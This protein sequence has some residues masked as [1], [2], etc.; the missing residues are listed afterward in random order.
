MTTAPHTLRTAHLGE[1]LGIDD[2]HPDL[3]WR[4]GRGRQHA[5]QVH[6]ATGPDLLDSGACDLWDSGRVAG[7]SGTGI[8][9][10]G[11]PPGA[12]RRVWWRVRVWCDDRPSPWSAAATWETGL[13]TESDWA[14][15]QWITARRTDSSSR[16]PLLAK[17]F[18][19]PRAPVTARLYATAL[20]TYEATVNGVAAGPALLEPGYTAYDKR[21]LYATYDITE[22]LR[23]G[24]NTVG[25]SLG[26]GIAH[27]PRV[28]GRYAKLHLDHGRPRARA[29]L[30]VV[31]ED[32]TS[33]TLVTDP[34]WRT[35]E[36]P[37]TL[38][39]WFGGEEHDARLAPHGW[40]RPGH[41]RRTWSA[42]VPAPLDGVRLTART[43][44][45][46]E[47]VDS[48]TPVSMSQPRP[49]VHVFDLGVNIAGRP[50]LKAAGPEGTAVVIRPGELLTADGTVNQRF[51]GSPCYDRYTLRGDP[52]GEEWAPATVYH[53]F[54]YLQVE[55]L[56]GQPAPDT[57][58]GEVMRAANPRAGGF[59]C[60][61]DLLNGIHR[62]IDRAVQGNM[63]SVLTDCPHREKLGWLEQ[64]HLVFPAVACGYDV[65]AYYR[66]LVRD[67]ADAQTESGLVPG[68]AP[69]YKVFEDKF[70]DDPN[71]G[72]ALVLAPWHL[73]RTYGDTSVL[74]AHYPDML[75][76]LEHLHSRSDDGLLLRHGLG[77]WITFD[78]STPKAVTATF[79]HHRIATALGDIAEA[80]GRTADA[81]AHRRLAHR[82][83]GAFHAE[84]FD[85]DRHTYGSGSQACDALAL[86]IGAVPP[87]ERPAVLDHLVAA[88]R[89]ADDH[90]TVGEIAL[91]ALLRV[92]SAHAR[93]DVV[94]DLLSRTDSPSYGYQLAHGATALTERWDGPTR[95]SSQNHF[96]LGA[97]AEWLIASLVGLRQAA[98]SVAYDH[99]V[100]RPAPVGDLT[101][102]SAWYETPRGRA[103]VT[104]HRGPDEFRL[105]VALPP[106]APSRVELPLPDGG[107]DVREVPPG[108]WEF[109]VPGRWSRDE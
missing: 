57:V 102:A 100:V 58:R 34:T 78:D 62:L 25:L 96:M 9:F 99:I 105:T 68:I 19:L 56:P 61:S 66:K 89:A 53:G 95:G 8:R 29:L 35:T 16:L 24:D 71:W 86:E 107:R 98:D 42:A 23:A 88:I 15:A 32:G 43:H 20:G 44:P 106:G 77:D 104:W 17:D 97:A 65:A 37:I 69:E 48:I 11:K 33:T 80:I 14:G 101:W 91:P 12:R 55:Q 93:D 41:D 49:G 45:P 47:V 21:L 72:G 82:I 2:Q 54:R 59:S 83:A 5:Y 92:L 73:Y 60:S 75:R 28:P 94:F 51:T 67:M 3:S 30:Y 103:G 7:T 1:P 76:Y 18:H 52:A 108:T 79:A 40:D 64:T 46:V 87:G 13:P 36:G 31:H 10:D 50:R 4:L 70:R 27:A 26:N 6:A 81:A 90:V 84:F 39:A 22:A 63:F 109:T 74:R 85:P 38:S